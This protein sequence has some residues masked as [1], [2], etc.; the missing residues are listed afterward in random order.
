MEK[1]TVVQLRQI[2]KERGLRGYSKLRK[3]ELIEFINR[4]T[5]SG[6]DSL[7]APIPEKENQK[8]ELV[9]KIDKTV[10]DVKR[11]AEGWGQWMKKKLTS[12]L[13]VANDKIKEFKDGVNKLY[14]ESVKPVFSFFKN[15]WS[16]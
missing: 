1:N 9:K 11:E 8:Q 3:A 12:P 16:Q 7:D 4:S 14:E 2:A 15:K 6:E 5:P 10:D 13:V